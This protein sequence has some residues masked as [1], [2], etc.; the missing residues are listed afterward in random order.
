[1]SAGLPGVSA[2]PCKYCDRQSVPDGM[3]PV[4]ALGASNV[5]LLEDERHPGRCVVA[6]HRHVRELFELTSAE[7]D[8]FMRDVSAVARAVSLA[9]QA[10]KVNIGFFGDL[11]DHL[12]AHA[13]PKHRDRSQWGDAFALQPIPPQAPD[14]LAAIVDR[15]RGALSA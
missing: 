6:S 15:I 1:M 2:K 5:L 4:L 8:A 10:H 12:H 14:A 3:R 7:R 13:V 9:T 11:S